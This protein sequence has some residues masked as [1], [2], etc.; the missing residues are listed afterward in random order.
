MV[1]M[2]KQSRLDGQVV[3][4]VFYQ[5]LNGHQNIHIHQVS[6]NLLLKDLYSYGFFKTNL[7]IHMEISHQSAVA[8]KKKMMGDK[9]GSMIFTYNHGNFSEHF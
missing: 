3:I 2:L 1:D 6:L 8:F 5:I 4:T 7:T 9:T